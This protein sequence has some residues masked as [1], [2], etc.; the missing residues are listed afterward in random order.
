MVRSGFNRCVMDLAVSELANMSLILPLCSMMILYLVYGTVRGFCPSLTPLSKPW[1]T[2]PPTSTN[3]LPRESTK[4]DMILVCLFSA[5]PS[6]PTGLKLLF[7]SRSYVSIRWNP[8]T[9]GRTRMYYIVRVYR[10]DSD[11]I[12]QTYPAQRTP[13]K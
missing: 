5:K 8:V 13:V 1:I 9:Q 4:C 12:F 11:T 6:A 2:V 10:P 7:T 3:N